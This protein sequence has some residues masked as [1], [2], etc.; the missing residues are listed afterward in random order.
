MLTAG[1][2]DRSR[3]SANAQRG[4]SSFFGARSI[5]GRLND[6]DGRRGATLAMR[7]VS[8]KWLGGLM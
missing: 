7:S 5:L 8:G 1:A 2:C 4:Y 3:G 6:G